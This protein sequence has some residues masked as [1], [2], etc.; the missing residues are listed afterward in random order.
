MKLVTAFR[1]K[2]CKAHERIDAIDI[3][4]R[5]LA[6]AKFIQF[7]RLNDWHKS[8]Q[9]FRKTA[10]RMTAEWVLCRVPGDGGFD[11]DIYRVR[12]SVGDNLSAG[13]EA[14]VLKVPAK[15]RPRD[16]ENDRPVDLICRVIRTQP[17]SVLLEFVCY[18]SDPLFADVWGEYVEEKKIRERQI[19][20]L[21]DECEALRACFGSAKTIG[22]ADFDPH[23]YRLGQIADEMARAGAFMRATIMEMDRGETPEYFEEEAAA[24]QSATQDGLDALTRVDAVALKDAVARLNDVFLAVKRTAP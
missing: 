12:R 16:P 18:E 24:W 6:D 5:Q 20:K 15:G 11:G 9:G 21:R 7:V 2:Q 1:E 17:N 3:R 10:P 19:E 23:G 8:H 22:R 13:I 14:R 4:M